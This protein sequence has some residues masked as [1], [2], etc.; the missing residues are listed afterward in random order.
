[1]AKRIQTKQGVYEI[2]DETEVWDMDD[3]FGPPD[4]E[5]SILK[6]I[7]NFDGKKYSEDDPDNENIHGLFGPPDTEESILRETDKLEKE[8]DRMRNDDDVPDP[9]IFDTS[10]STDLDLP[11]EK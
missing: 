6:E 9:L 11:E 5:E 2:T 10:T 4:T 7:E 8:I 3:L 1:M